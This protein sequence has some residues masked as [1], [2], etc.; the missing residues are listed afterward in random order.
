MV[1]YLAKF[2]AVHPSAAHRAAI[3]ILGFAL[4]RLAH[5]TAAVPAARELN[6]RAVLFSHS[7]PH[8]EKPRPSV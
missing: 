4:G 2:A 8:K 7:V 3:K 5:P 1:E 6:D